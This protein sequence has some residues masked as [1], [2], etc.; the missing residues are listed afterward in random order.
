MSRLPL[1]MQAEAAQTVAA[2]T[3]NSRRFISDISAPL[4]LPNVTPMPDTRSGGMLDN[5]EQ[6]YHW[7][8]GL[9]SQNRIVAMGLQIRYSSTAFPCRAHPIHR[10]VLKALS[11]AVPPFS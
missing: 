3:T 4:G 7:M 10:A 1:I 6:N 5:V 2:A 11:R 9:L 8:Q